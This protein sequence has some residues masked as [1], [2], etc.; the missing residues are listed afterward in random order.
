[1]LPK[2]KF[3]VGSVDEAYDCICYLRL[4]KCDPVPEPQR[5]YQFP[6]SA[7]LTAFVLAFGTDVREVGNTII[8]PDNR[9]VD[10]EAALQALNLSNAVLCTEVFAL[11]V[12]GR[13]DEIVFD[14]LF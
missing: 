9:K 11:E 4:T 5:A 10:A 13:E 8:I 14:T 12:W 7:T 3:Y 1:M 2:L 6:S